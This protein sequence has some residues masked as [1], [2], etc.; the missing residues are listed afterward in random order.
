M[1]LT[2]LCDILALLAL[3]PVLALTT[4]AG[5]LWLTA[6]AQ[7]AASPLQTLIVLSGV[8]TVLLAVLGWTIFRITGG[9]SLVAGISLAAAGLALLS[10]GYP[11]WERNKAMRTLAPVFASDFGP[12]EALPDL[13]R[14]RLADYSDG[15]TYG[16]GVTCRVDCLALLS[17]GLVQE[18]VLS[19][20]FEMDPTGYSVSLD[21]DTAGCLRTEGCVKTTLSDRDGPD[22]TLVR[23]VVH[24]NGPAPLPRE[25]RHM[26]ILALMRTE[27][28]V[29][30]RPILRRTSVEIVG[31]QAFTLPV[32]DRRGRF[33]YPRQPVWLSPQ[34]L[35]AHAPLSEVLRAVMH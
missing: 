33:A 14:L 13:S 35:T 12:V 29:G 20:A 6:A 31:L 11:A 25:A 4:R 30:N 9:V 8:L 19:P 3:I 7:Q 22:V 17:E 10:L 2:R 21:R 15:Q 5:S 24:A 27:I 1:Q 18:V 34:P 26:G 23:S 28:Y 32:L 16:R